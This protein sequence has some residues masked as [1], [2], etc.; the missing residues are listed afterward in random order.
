MTRL[1]STTLLLS[2]GAVFACLVL[3]SC[4]GG[5]P[6]VTPAQQAEAAKIFEQR[7]TICHGATGDGDGPG[8]AALTPKPRKFKDKEW[9][10]SITDDHIRKIIVGGGAAVGKSPTMVPNPDLKDKPG[11]VQAL[12]EKVRSFAK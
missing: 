9:Q 12:V 8:S 2:F 6:T 10:A 4:G 11:V 5:G 1:F 7:C 3:P